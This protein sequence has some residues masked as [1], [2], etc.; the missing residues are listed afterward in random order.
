MGIAAAKEPTMEEIL[1]SIRKIVTQ[2]G[3]EQAAAPAA[4]DTAR[5]PSLASVANSVRSASP[6]QRPATQPAAGQPADTPARSS[7]AAFAEQI[8]GRTPA[9]AASVERR[10]T[11]ARAVAD[12]PARV[13]KP[14]LASLMQSLGRKGDGGVSETAQSETKVAATTAEVVQKPATLQANRPSMAD[15]ATAAKASQPV[16]VAAARQQASTS[17]ATPVRTAP[18]AGAQTSF[19]AIA[20]SARNPVPQ[21]TAAHATATQATSAQ[22]VA[23]PAVAAQA[24]KSEVTPAPSRN[25]EPAKAASEATEVKASVVAA[26]PAEVQ[27]TVAE[28]AKPAA[29]AGV[30]A[31]DIDAF[32]GELLG[33]LSSPATQ[34]AVAGSLDRLK[35]AAI[36]K[37]DAQVETLLRPIMREW[38][39]Q[40]L[41]AIVERLVREEIERIA[42]AD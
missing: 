2:D 36:D 6:G 18:V 24:S 15:I 34:Q 8:S 16:A 42:R 23:A 41:P 7:F 39:D 20:A 31:S 5:A 17:A 19:A 27:K 32:R 35:K 25:I 3:E 11:P 22:A 29:A 33:T 21:A 13:E 10:E 26:K 38:I 14:S 4:R 1:A 30:Q 28:V 12:N 37:L 40:H 9:G